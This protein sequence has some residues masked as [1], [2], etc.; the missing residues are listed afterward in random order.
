M[1]QL[2]I[3]LISGHNQNLGMLIEIGLSMLSSYLQSS[4]ANFKDRM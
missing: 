2:N 3:V 4:K 1:I